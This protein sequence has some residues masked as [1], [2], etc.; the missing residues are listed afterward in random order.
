MGP[1]HGLVVHT[2]LYLNKT[3]GTNAMQST[4]ADD[5]MSS[6]ESGDQRGPETEVKMYHLLSQ[7]DE[8]PEHHFSGTSHFDPC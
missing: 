3:W 2:L 5:W 4:Q 6:T 7:N 8:E 1:G